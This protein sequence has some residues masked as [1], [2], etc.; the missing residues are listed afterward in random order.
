[1]K[2]LATVFGALI[3]ALIFVPTASTFKQ[4]PSL[5]EVAAQIALQPVEVR[6]YERGEAEDPWGVGAWG[7]VYIGIPV[8]H[9]AAEVCDGALGI[10]DNSQPKWKQ[11][12]GALVL[13]HESYHLN[14][15]VL[16]PDNEA[17]TECRA[18]KHTR[19]TMLRLGASENQADELMPYALAIH[20]RIAAKYPEY[21]W[22][23]C[24]VPWY[25]H[26]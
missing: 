18:I 6:C 14:L 12:L 21:N 24:D 11:A 17:R 2:A 1:M 5:A 25:W 3:L 8:E 9:M 19:E 23:P 15:Q 10:H 7:Y 22:K 4:A 20:Y 13:A 26:S 16:H